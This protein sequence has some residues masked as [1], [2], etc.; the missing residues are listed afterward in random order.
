MRRARFVG[1][2]FVYGVC[3][4]AFSAHIGKRWCCEKSAPGLSPAIRAGQRIAAFAHGTECGENTAFPAFV[5]VHW[6][7][8][9]QFKSGDNGIETSPEM[10]FTGPE[11]FGMMSKSKI[12]V[13]S[14]SVAKAFGMSTTPDM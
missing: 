4:S 11:A 13:G 8:S 9:P 14:Q 6:H 2:L 5:I 12:S 7:C 1:R 3:V 10:A